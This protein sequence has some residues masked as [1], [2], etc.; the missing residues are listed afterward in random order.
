[1]SNIQI[2]MRGYP[3]TLLTHDSWSFQTPVQNSSTMFL[4]LLTQVMTISNIYQIMLIIGATP[5]SAYAHARRLVHWIR[6]PKSTQSKSSKG[7]H[8]MMVCIECNTI[9]SLPHLSNY[10]NKKS[11]NKANKRG[12]MWSWVVVQKSG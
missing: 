2:R 12:K 9:C 5:Q 8:G 1:M 7:T 6:L 10:G 11:D 4:L 3:W